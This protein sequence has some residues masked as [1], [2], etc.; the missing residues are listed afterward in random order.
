MPTRSSIS[1][2]VS[3]ATAADHVVARLAL[4]LRLIRSLHTS[5]LPLMPVE[6]DLRPVMS[7]AILVGGVVDDGVIHHTVGVYPGR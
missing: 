7:V 2:V 4:E 5:A 3:Y 6:L 1:C